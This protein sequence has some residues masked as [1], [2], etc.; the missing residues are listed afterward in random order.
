MN[1]RV[2]KHFIFLLLVSGHA[3]LTRYVLA[4]E[5]VDSEEAIITPEIPADI[6]ERNYSIYSDSRESTTAPDRDDETPSFQPSPIPTE[7]EPLKILGEYVQ[8]GHFRVL[9]WVSGQS[10]SGR[11]VK[12]PVLVVRGSNPG[13][14]LCLV[15]AIHGDELNGIEIVRRVVRGLDAGE[16][17]G[18]VI[19]VPIV[20]LFGFTGNSRYLPDRRDLNRYFPGNVTGSAASR[21][22]HRFFNQIIRHCH[23]VVDFHTGSFKRNNL[24]QLRADMNNPQV[25]EF[26]AHFG[27]TVV[28]HKPGH[29]KTLRAA[30]TQAG[31]PTVVFELGQPGSVQESYVKAGMKA[32]DALLANL[33]MVERLRLWFEP[34][35]VYYSSRWIRVNNGGIL[36]SEVKIGDEVPAGG[37]LGHIINPLTSVE[38]EIHSPVN[39]R[40]LGM[41]LNQFMLPGYAAFHIGVA[42][43]TRTLIEQQPSG[44]EEDAND[45]L[46]DE[47]GEA[48]D[49]FEKMPDHEEEL[50]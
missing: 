31:I 8:P 24:P 36:F 48:E 33:E 28:L 50:H 7:A 42:A 49:G 39:G 16:L 15:A 38:T 26:V 45:I 4:T 35:P 43:D 29:G 1:S 3:F 10:F 37:L 32:L 44:G 2:C 27:S 13:P 6:T 19:G 34:Q 25:R 20:N 17:N 40:V 23:Y 9:N 41:A 30:A 46:D 5:V 22:A 18:T 11:T 12:P 21:I 47:Y 14:V